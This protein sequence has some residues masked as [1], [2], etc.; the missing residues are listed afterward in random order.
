MVLRGILNK[1]SEPGRI[2]LELTLIVP[3]DIAL[4]L[5]FKMMALP[6]TVLCVLPVFEKT[7]LRLLGKVK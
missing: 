3:C 2:K 5:L 6:I 7:A 4:Y 1:R